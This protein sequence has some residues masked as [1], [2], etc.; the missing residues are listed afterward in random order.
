[1]ICKLE[2]LSDSPRHHVSKLPS[3][4]FNYQFRIVEHCNELVVLSFC[5]RGREPWLKKGS[6]SSVLFSA[7]KGAGSSTQ[8]ATRNFSAEPL[9]LWLRSYLPYS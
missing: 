2:V 4:K 8:T 7:S 3:I 6:A 9:A 5:F 1:M